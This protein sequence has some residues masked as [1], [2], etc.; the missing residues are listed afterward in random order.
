M[1]KLRQP[2]VYLYIEL[3]QRGGNTLRLKTGGE[4]F[5]TSDSSYPPNEDSLKII[6]K[7]IEEN[8]K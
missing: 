5:K 3:T 6:K 4:M 7:I 8:R 1:K 2:G